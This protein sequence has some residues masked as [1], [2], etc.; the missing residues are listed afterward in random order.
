MLFSATMPDEIS[1]LVDTILINP[2][3]VAVTAVS[4]TVDTIEQYLYFVN[5]G[6]KRAL[7]VHLLNNKSVASALVFSRTKHGAN[8]IAKHLI[9]AGIPSEAI[10]SNKSQTAR[11]LALNNFKTK[12]TR[13]LVAT[14]I[15]ARGIDIDELSH[16]INFDLPE[17]PE[18]YV[19]RIGRTGRAGLGGIA[20]SFC[21]NDEKKLLAEIQKLISKSIP[22]VDHHPYPLITE[23][24]VEVRDIPHKTG[25]TR[26]N[27]R[28]F[29]GRNRQK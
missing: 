1:K 19:H 3:K 20:L 29:T 17:V 5:K 21:D 25:N 27:S 13:V 6:N 11:Q 15:A 10:H 7:L 16:V 26:S 9:K 2:S 4:S 28:N 8:N 12:K 22:V 18:T 14:D 23:E 24:T